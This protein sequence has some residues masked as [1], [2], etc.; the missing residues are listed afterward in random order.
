MLFFIFFSTLWKLLCRPWNKLKSR[1]STPERQMHYESDPML[2]QKVQPLHICN[3]YC[4]PIF[5]FGYRCG[6]YSSLLLYFFYWKLFQR[7]KLSTCFTRYVRIDV[8]TSVCT[9]TFRIRTAEFTRFT[10]ERA[11][12]HTVFF[13][14]KS[15]YTVNE[16]REISS[17]PKRWKSLPVSS[18]SP[19][20]RH[21]EQKLPTDQRKRQR[22]DNKGFVREQG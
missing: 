2:A 17:H 11:S 4:P 16:S 7:G 9:H 22:L 6:P 19:C 5:Q 20:P 10:T 14:I 15:W 13:V 21:F 8:P 18:D 1:R 3:I 12:W